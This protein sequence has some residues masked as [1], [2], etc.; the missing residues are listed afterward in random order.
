LFLYSKT[1]ILEFLQSKEKNKANKL[2]LHTNIPHNPI[3][4]KI[5][6]LSKEN[7]I[8]IIQTN[9]KNIIQKKNLIIQ[10]KEKVP[11][12]LEIS[13]FNYS[14]LEDIENNK[15]S[16]SLIVFAYKVKDPRN[17]GAI[18]RVSSG[19][20]TKGVIITSKDSCS[21]NDTVLNSSRNAPILVHRTIKPIN[22]INHLKQKNYEIFCLDVKGKITINQ[23]S[24]LNKNVLLILGGEKGV[25][26]KIK[27]LS[28]T[29]NI[30]IKNVESLN[31][32]NALSI[33]LYHL[34]NISSL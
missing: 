21:V 3:I 33:F 6:K 29:V 12:I 17:L 7:N 19:F 34:K 27:E 11:V 9:I 5:I 10:N 18:L 15:T 28:I 31:T 32:S 25:D 16:L 30:P 13:Q 1:L 2:Y 14:S 8:P 24:K 22:T 26:Q 20:D 23:I 4:S